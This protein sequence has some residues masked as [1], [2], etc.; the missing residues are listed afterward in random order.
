M[1]FLV[2]LALLIALFWGAKLVKKGSWND[3]WMSLSQTK[4][5]QGFTAICIMLHHCAQK[6]CAP[7]LAPR[8][9]VHGLDG[10]VRMG[11]IFVGVFLFCS[12]YGLYK[13]YK[14]KPNYLEG[15]CKKRILPVVL[16]FYVTGYLFLI[17]RYALGLRPSTGR[18]ICYLTGIQLSNPNAWFV[19][20]LPIFYL[21]FYFSFRFCKKESHAIF[22]TCFVVFV[23]TL[24][25]TCTNHNE[26]WMRGEWWYNSVHFFPLGLLFA[27][28]E[29]RVTEKI[30]CHYVLWMVVAIV[31]F[32]GFSRLSIYVQN[33]I[34]YYGEDYN[35][36]LI[37]LR[38]WACL[39]VQ[40]VTS[41]SFVFAIFMAG[42][43]IKIGN[44]FLAFMGTIT[45]EFYLI[46]GL[47]IE[48]F[49]Y[50]FLDVRPSLYYIRNVTLFVFVVFACSIPS[51]LLLKK[52]INLGK[53]KKKSSKKESM[54]QSERAS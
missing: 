40:M 25:G 20:A 15:F 30:K 45:M 53:G 27:R 42:L 22:C 38:R 33:T 49:G 16:A 29:K 46:H 31:S 34:S 24:I 5:L 3:E 32:I 17:V 21:G 36:N 47:F 35:L 52:A 10:F 4:A 37:P 2:Y 48:F 8:V 39:L 19:V 6:T 28:Y 18:L 12:G 44:K 11:Y 9:I 7:W 54:V 1:I 14:T 23:Y 43:K 13:S 51:A 41:C 26:F 50:S